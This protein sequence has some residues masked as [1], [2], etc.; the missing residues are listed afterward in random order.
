MN[1]DKKFK[2]IYL[3]NVHFAFVILSNKNQKKKNRKRCKYTLVCSLSKVF[4]H[5]WLKAIVVAVVIYRKY[6]I[7]IEYTL[8]T[9]VKVND[10]QN[11]L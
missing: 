8:C 11:G 3:S 9:C 6:I 4:P 2:E 7:C 5:K 1:V 10:Q